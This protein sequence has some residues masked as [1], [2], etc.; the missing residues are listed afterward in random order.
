[1]EVNSQE[2]AAWIP[3]QVHLAS[4]SFNFHICR[5]DIYLLWLT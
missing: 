1:M 3:I 4:L 5:G 2:K